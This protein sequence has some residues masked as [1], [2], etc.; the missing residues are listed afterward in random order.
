MRRHQPL[1]RRQHYIPRFVLREFADRN[2]L[3]WWTK[4]GGRAGNPCRSRPRNLFVKK[5]LYSFEYEDGLTD[6][7]E[8]I[9]AKKESEW[10]NAFSRIKKL[11]ATRRDDQIGARDG[12]LM[13]E[14]FLY[15]GIRTPEHLKRT[16]YEGDHEPREL[17]DNLVSRRL[18]EEEY[19]LHERN[20]R[21]MLG[22]GQA[23]GVKAE[24]QE[25]QNKRGLAIC[26]LK[27]SMSKLLV[28]SYGAAP[29]KWRRQY[30]Y[31]I[32]AAPDM[33]LLC[34][35]D[36][37]RTVVIRT[38]NIKSTE[39]SRVMNAATWNRSTFVAAASRSTLECAKNLVATAIAAT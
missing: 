33:A 28:G 32:P 8:H 18:T 20:A 17:I 11:L 39:M 4:T 36:P 16:M 21:A 38:S 26:K 2:G 9:L 25:L 24:I 13:L 34:T 7:F 10:S 15:A 30:V 5:D 23:D 19:L 37:D 31:F 27:G 35:G 14:Y 29:I 1:V 6:E 3:I 12:K 22:S